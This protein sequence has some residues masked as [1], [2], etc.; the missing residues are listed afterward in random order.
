MTELCS[1]RAGTGKRQKNKTLI[2]C[3]LHWTCIKRK[4]Q[5]EGGSRQVLSERLLLHGKKSGSEQEYKRGKKDE[6]KGEQDN[7]DSWKAQTG[8][9]CVGWGGGGGGGGVCM[10]DVVNSDEPP[11]RKSGGHDSLVQKMVCLGRESRGSHRPLQE[12]K[13]V[14]D[15]RN[16]GMKATKRE[17]CH[18]TAGTK[19]RA[20]EHQK[21][22]RLISMLQ[23][24]KQKL[25]KEKDSL[26]KGKVRST[27]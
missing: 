20:K 26:T 27:T 10:G 9:S 4:V 8:E 3:G 1:K 11:K 18:G 6:K 13:D 19:K 14:K 23:E 17:H 21:K 7:S 2:S 16:A 25:K 15:W 22:R 24:T 5:R 12:N